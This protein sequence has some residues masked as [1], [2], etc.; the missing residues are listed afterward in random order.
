MASVI[1]RFKLYF[2]K[3]YEKHES[4]VVNYSK[5]K[6]HTESIVLIKS[7]KFLFCE[8]A[9]VESDVFQRNTTKNITTY[10]H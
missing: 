2:K 4:P 8:V 10:R 9:H 6:Y 3:V 5:Q 1:K 7:F